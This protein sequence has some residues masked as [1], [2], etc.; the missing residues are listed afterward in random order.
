[1]LGTG[2]TMYRTL[3]AMHEEILNQLP[4][5]MITEGDAEW[6]E[7]SQATLHTAVKIVVDIAHHH[8]GQGENAD[9][10]PP[11]CIYSIRTAHKHAEKIY[12]TVRD[13]RSFDQL[14]TIRNL[15]E[16][17]SFGESNHD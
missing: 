10:A 3:F 1:M 16:N 15:K 12:T 13:S 8:M 4:K 2:L 11:C 17:L 7:A 14:N 5:S 6:A 9:I